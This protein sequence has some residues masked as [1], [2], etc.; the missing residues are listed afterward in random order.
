[1][2][3]ILIALAIAAIAAPGAARDRGQVPE[4]TPT[5]KPENCVTTS[6]IRTTH[7]RNDSVI[8]FE[9]NGGQIYRNTL[10]YA[11]PSLGFDQ[12]FGYETH[13]GELCSID[14][15]TVLRTGAGTRGP[16]CGLGEFQPVKLAR[17]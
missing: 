15:I 5:G 12:A 2:R 1:M 17:K 6:R 13:T 7:V 8:D 14:T 4:A 16:T 10:P 11:C 9:M 3:M